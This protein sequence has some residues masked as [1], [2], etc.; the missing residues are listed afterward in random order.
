LLAARRLGS[1]SDNEVFDAELERDVTFG[2]VDLRA[3]ESQSEVTLT[4]RWWDPFGAGRQLRVPAAH[5]APVADCGAGELERGP[6]RIRRLAGVVPV[7]DELAEHR[8]PV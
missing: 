7:E 2:L 1:V 4:N 5:L 3:F 6:V 8:V